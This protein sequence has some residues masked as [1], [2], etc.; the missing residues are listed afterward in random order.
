MTST[1][2]SIKDIP[3]SGYVCGMFNHS[4]IMAR[5]VFTLHVHIGPNMAGSVAAAEPGRP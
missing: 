4:V 5:H 1:N 2:T 3:V